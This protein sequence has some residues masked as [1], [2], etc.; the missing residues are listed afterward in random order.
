MMRPYGSAFFIALVAGKKE[1]PPSI[2][3]IFESARSAE[4][5]QNSGNDFAI[6]LMTCPD[7]VRVATSLPASKLGRADSHP[8]GSSRAT[9]RFRSAARSG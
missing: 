3:V 6:A 1:L 5:P 8:A 4:P 2:V 9:R 7:A